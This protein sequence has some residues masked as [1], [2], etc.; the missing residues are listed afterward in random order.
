MRK[1]TVDELFDLLRYDTDGRFYSVT[2]ERRGTR[3]DGSQRPGDLRT[4]LCKTAATM[5][6]YKRGVISNE[7]RDEEDL[8]CAV[9]TVWDVQ[10]FM[11]NIKRGMSKW[12]AGYNAWRRIDL[13]GLK[14]CSLVELGE[15]P[16]TIRLELH[17][18][19]R[20]SQ[21]QTEQK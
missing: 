8:R 3:R 6:R 13:A 10:A 12:S 19:T 11:R 9:L 20:N 21:A 16:P 2:F 5:T 7:H 15:L 1:L 4:M 17:A 18:A 14:E